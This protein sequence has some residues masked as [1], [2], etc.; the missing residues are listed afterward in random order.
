M[1]FPTIFSS[2][3]DSNSVR[4]ITAQNIDKKATYRDH[5]A[6]ECSPRHRDK[7]AYNEKRRVDQKMIVASRHSTS[8]AKRRVR[9][10][11]D[12]IDW[13]ARRANGAASLQLFSS[14]TGETRRLGVP[15]LS[16]LQDASSDVRRHSQHR[17]GVAHVGSEA[18]AMA[19]SRETAATR[20]RKPYRKGR[21]GHR[22]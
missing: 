8:R 17:C 15:Q 16:H 2:P 14:G 18:A 13:A 12:P 11:L 22:L 6:S 4:P 19:D 5:Y 10:C 1:S 9:G 20:R 21:H 7:S 3:A